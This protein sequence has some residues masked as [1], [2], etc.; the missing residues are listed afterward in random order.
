MIIVAN[1][2]DHDHRRRPTGKL[3]DSDLTLSAASMPLAATA[4]ELLASL[5]L[6]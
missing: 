6:A 5:R 3:L 2:L 1:L 4:T